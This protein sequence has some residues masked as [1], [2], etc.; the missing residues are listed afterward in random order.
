MKECDG[1]RQP[2]PFCTGCQLL[3]KITDLIQF[4]GHLHA[5]LIRGDKR[6]ELRKCPSSKFTCQGD[7]QITF[8]S[9]CT[10][11]HLCGV[12]LSPHDCFSSSSESV[13]FP[14]FYEQCEKKLLELLEIKPHFFFWPKGPKQLLKHARVISGTPLVVLSLSASRAEVTEG[15]L[16]MHRKTFSG[17]QYILGETI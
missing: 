16:R 15:D 6:S 14:L 7:N 13:A 8:E 11:R 5:L 9:I 4:K 2:A 1:K 12:V 3:L 10:S 17:L